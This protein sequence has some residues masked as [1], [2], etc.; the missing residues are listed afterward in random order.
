MR[1]TFR[2]PTDD[3]GRGTLPLA[4][5]AFMLV[6]CRAWG[7]DTLSGPYLGQELPGTTPMIFAPGVVSVDGT[8][9][10]SLSLSPHGD[11]LFFTRSHGWPHTRVMYMK[12]TGDAWSTPEIAP[13]LKDDWATQAVFSPDGQYLYFSSSRGRS[14]IE[15]YSLWRSRKT[16]NGWSEP[17]SVVD[18]GGKMMM[19]FHPS[20][21][22]DGSLYFLLWDFANQ[23]GDLYVCQ[24]V[25]GKHGEPVRLDSPIS[26]EFN[27]VRPTVDPNGR[28]LLFESNRPGGLGRTDIYIAFKN[29]DGTWSAPRNLGPTINTPEV[30]DSPNISPDG[31]YWFSS[32]NGNIFWRQA[33][34]LGQR[35]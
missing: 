20:V 6:A 34:N 9:E 28:Y 21:A 25:D 32:V 17:E 11:E 7:A 24:Q 35:P 22:R 18:L 2:R 16:E 13:F 10:R 27:E 19:E 15:H 26:T 1:T 12:K 30:D 3:A 33:P 31:K 23:T 5:L 29:D 4:C 14:D 8:T